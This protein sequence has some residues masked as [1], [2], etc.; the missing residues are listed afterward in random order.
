MSISNN[1]TTDFIDLNGDPGERTAKFRALAIYEVS[2]SIWSEI[3]PVYVRLQHAI[4]P[5]QPP[6]HQPRQ[7]FHNPLQ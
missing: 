1:I 7:V 4:R 5:P 6:T 2:S 3:K